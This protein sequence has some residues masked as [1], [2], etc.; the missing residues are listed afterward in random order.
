[1]EHLERARVAIDRCEALTSEASAALDR[2]VAQF[3]RPKAAG[4]ARD[5][6]GGEKATQPSWASRCSSSASYQTELAPLPSPLVLAPLPPPA[7][8]TGGAFPRVACWLRT[9]S[10]VD[11]GGCWPAGHG[12]SG[13]GVEELRQA[14]AWLQLA[15]THKGAENGEPG[16]EAACVEMDL[17]ARI[18]EL[19]REVA[20]L[21]AL[22]PQ[23]EPMEQK[24]RQT[25]RVPVEHPITC[26]LLPFPTSSNSIRQPCVICSP[27]AVIGR[28]LTSR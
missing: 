2:A 25:A 6:Q 17:R 20:Q 3:S 4:P 23:Q 13:M 12:Q 15:S 26:C 21:I 22:R 7:P 28:C 11:N 9:T 18:K 24:Q 8:G 14:M 1:M 16:D 10:G 19:E 27:G 5:A